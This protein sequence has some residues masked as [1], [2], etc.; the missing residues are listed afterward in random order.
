MQEEN[1]FRKQ[2]RRYEFLLVAVIGARATSFIFSKII[3]QQME[4]F[5][6]LAVR[7]LLAFLLLAFLFWKR[8]RHITGS[9]LIKGIVIGTLF[10][11]TMSLEMLSLK[12][13][14]SSLVSLLENTAILFVPVLE[15]I[16]FKKIPDRITV[17][18]CL[19]AMGGVILLA[20]SQGSLD[21]GFTLGIFS[22]ISYAVSIIVTEK[23]SRESKETLNIGIIQVG[24]MGILSLLTSFL[25]EAPKLPETGISWFMIAILILVC[26]GFGFTLQPVAQ[27][28]VTAERAGL[29]CAVSPAIAALLGIFVLHERL[30]LFG[31][32]GLVMILLS[33]LLPYIKCKRV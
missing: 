20:V 8:I 29:F 31:G 15:L 10:F 21:G 26:T 27:S 14:A 2:N 3:L 16:F 17:I 5:N 22:G 12:Q 24:T 11:L 18:C 25:L 6:L 4:P 13:A 33:I 28:H 1:V 19:T 32:I 23:L 9:D 30:G 7:F